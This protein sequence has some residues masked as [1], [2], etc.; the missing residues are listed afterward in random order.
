MVKSR[1]EKQVNCDLQ[2][3]QPV[4]FNTDTS[5]LEP[6]FIFEDYKKHNFTFTSNTHKIMPLSFVGK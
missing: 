2:V 6:F 4:G 1:E 5:S 3:Q